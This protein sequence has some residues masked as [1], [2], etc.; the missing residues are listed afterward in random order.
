MFNS[1]ASPNQLAQ[2]DQDIVVK[3]A[4][5][6]IGGYTIPLLGIPESSTLE[7]CDKCGQERHITEIKHTGKRWVCINAKSCTAKSR[8][9]KKLK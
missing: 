4:T 7:V 3:Y 1:R 9:R 2:P 6:K 5:T 8:A